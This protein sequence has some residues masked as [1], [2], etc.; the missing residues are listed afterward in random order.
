MRRMKEVPLVGEKNPVASMTHR[1]W[2]MVSKEIKDGTVAARDTLPKASTQRHESSLNCLRGRNSNREGPP[3]MRQRPF[4]EENTARLSV[5]AADGRRI[6]A[7]R[8]TCRGLIQDKT[9]PSG[10]SDDSG[11]LLSELGG[12][13]HG[14]SELG[15]SRL[16]G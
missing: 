1:G 15:L 10:P 5:T 16:G 9:G 3:A 4:P 8:A 7:G 12:N 11:G 6:S 14:G 2:P 13:H